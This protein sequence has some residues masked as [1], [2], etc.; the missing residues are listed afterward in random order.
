MRSRKAVCQI[1]SVLSAIICVV[2]ANAV[3][4]G[5]S[6]ADFFS[7][8]PVVLSV[9]RLSQPTREAP[10]AVMVINAQQ[11]RDSGAR[12]IA[13]LLRLVPGFQVAQSRNGAPV[14]VYH[15][16][17]SE[18]P[19][20]LQ[21]L[22]DGRTQ[23]SPLWFGGVNWNTL[24]VSLEDIERIEVIRGSNSA[25]FGSNAFLG[26]LNV[27]TRH[28]SQVPGVEARV[29]QGSGGVADRYGRLGWSTGEHRFR[30]S[31]EQRKDDGLQR[32]YDS[33]KLEQANFRGDVRLTNQDVLQLSA[34]IQRVEVGLGYKDRVDSG[35]NLLPPPEL[36][37][38][39]NRKFVNRHYQVGWTRQINAT[40]DLSFRYFHVD[41]WGLER[42]QVPLAPLLP[43]SLIVDDSPHLERNDIE[44]QHTLAI[45]DDHRLMW[46]AGYRKDV[47]VSALMYGTNDAQRAELS[48]LF[49]NFEWRMAPTW[50]FNL[51]G[52]Y[53][54]ENLS[55]SRF[56]PRAMLN[57]HLT[58][59]QTLRLGASRAHRVPS[60]F[61]QR[62][63]V[64]FG[65]PFG[66]LPLDIAYAARGSVKP[67]V[68]NSIE[69]G[70]LGEFRSSGAVVDVR[71]FKER[72]DDRLTKRTYSLT[73]PGCD[74]DGALSG[75]CGGAEEF[76][77]DKRVTIEGVEYQVT[78]HPT[79]K[80]VVSFGQALLALNADLYS[81]ADRAAIEQSAPKHSE[82]VTLVQQLPYG[83]RL[84]GS[85][86]WV[87]GYKWTNNSNIPS[88]TRMD[89]QLAYPFKLGGGVKGEVAYTARSDN[90]RHAE[91]R[92]KTGVQWDLSEPLDPVH[93]LSLRME[94]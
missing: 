26:V 49:G 30:L 44:M 70:Y 82:V 39:R 81:P 76:V 1:G 32:F 22:I 93:F 23:Y 89:W 50:I 17:T 88:Y 69:L 59:E 36:D 48:R 58:A 8:L 20:G 66:G 35:G 6:E 21:I 73:P 64:E 78:L 34:G 92:Y 12:D 54:H 60:L 2:Q 75:G 91:Y 52:T 84:T 33:R 4:A 19:R 56:A 14:A 28:A 29:R 24:Q 94:Y 62:A 79:D 80:T 46:G 53:E 57:H 61:E 77:N 74:V 67:E 40:D 43:A 65:P 55:G 18:T 42:Y 15:G 68:I 47:I 25:A 10:G 31:V 63:N 90:G 13:D 16:L 87:G 5:V 37:P 27:V 86:Y 3:S 38:E 71:A 9:S 7:E 85:H 83:I 72:V 45:G 51:G 41:E 11:I